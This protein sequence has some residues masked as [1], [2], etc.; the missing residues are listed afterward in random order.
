MGRYARWGGVLLGLWLT[1]AGAATE[2]PEPLRGWEAWV[3]HG[4]DFRQCPIQDLNTLDSADGYACSLPDTVRIEI[5]AGQAQVRYTQRVYAAGY[6]DLVYADKV[7]P[8][9]LS[10]DGK[11]AAVMPGYQGPRLWLEPGEHALSY[12]LDL[13][14]AP[15]AL[16]VPVAMRLLD[17]SV[18]GR[19]IFP[20]AREG[21][22][23]WLE[24]QVSTTEAD[25]LDTTV[26]RLWSDGIPQRLTTRIAL[27][28]AGKAREIRLGPAWPEGYELVSVSGS[29]PA[30]VEPGRMLRVQATAGSYQLELNARATALA[31]TLTASLP[32]DNWPAQE[33]WSFA[34]DHR[35]RVVDVSGNAPIDPAQGDVPSDWRS[36]PAYAMTEG[37][38][39]SLSERSR[40]LGD[41]A[42]RVQLQRQLWLDFDGGGYT[43]QDQLSGRMRQGF[44][45]DLAAPYELLAASERGES[46]LVTEGAGAGLRGVE[47][48]YPNLNLETTA[49]LPALLQLPAHGWNERLDGVSVSLHLPPGYR[50]LQASGVDRA[51]EAWIERWD[52]YEVFIAAFT[53]VLAWRFGGLRLAG[54]VAVLVVL[55][56]HEP[57]VP[58]YSLIALLLLAIAW[59]MLPVGR[60]R[61]FVAVATLLCAGAFALAALPFA[62]DQARWALHPQLAGGYSVS[63]GL[64]F[65][66]AARSEAV[67][68][69]EAEG[70]V[71]AE[72]APPPP[73]APPAP[74]APMAQEQ[75]QQNYLSNVQNSASNLRAKRAGNLERYAKDAVVQAG[76]GRPTWSWEQVSLGFDGPVD[77]AQM[78]SLWLLPPWLT[79]LW[80]LLLVAALA[81]IAL[82]LTFSVRRVRP[83]P[84]AAA[85][86]LLLGG[87]A[88][89]AELP[90]ASWLEA[91][92]QR[93]TEAPACAPQCVRLAET[94]VRLDGNRLQL[95]AEVHAEASLLVPVPIDDA[96]LLDVAVR[97]DGQPAAVLG[98]AEGSTAGWVAVTRG[99]HRIDLVAEVRGDRV[100]LDFSLTPA[101][102]QA[103]VPGW[104]VTGLRDGHLLS[105]RL[106]LVREAASEAAAGSPTARVPIK[107][108]VRIER[109]ISLDLD[110]TVSTR[111]IRL[112]P[113]D[114]GFSVRVP[115]L[116]GEQPGDAGLKVEDGR[117]EVT[118]QPGVWETTISSRLPR[119]ETLTL[120]AP[121]I[122]ERAEVWRVLVGPSLSMQA[123]GVPVSEPQDGIGDELW[124][125]EFNPLPGE[126][127]TL[128]I[129]RPAAVPGATLVAD[130]VTL[131]SDIG[132][133]SSTHTLSLQLRATQGGSHAL[134][135][136]EGAELLSVAINGSAL[137]LKLEAGKL[138]LPVRPGAQTLELSWRESAGVGLINRTPLVDLGLD[139]ANIRL[140]L[141]LP[142]DRWL[143]RLSGPA[144]GP[145]VLYW[146]GLIVL[147][148]IGYGLGRSGRALLPAG[149]W[150][151]LVLGFSTFSYIPLFV[152]AIGFLALDARQRYLPGALGKW[153]FDLIQLLVAG[154]TVAAFLALVA[155]IPAGLL[156]SPDMHIAGGTGAYSSP[157]WLADRAS[158]MLP[159]AQ[160]ISLPMWAYKAA[161]L[162]FALWL[163]YALL[164]WI[165]LAWQA[166]T[167]GGGWKPLRRAAQTAPAAPAATPAPGNE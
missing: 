97:L 25:A 49:R 81:G 116:A 147:L 69:D 99:V 156:G 51:P 131:S 149:H 61:M 15:D 94:T 77:S 166:L 31:D 164:R 28:V 78:V 93:L 8:R 167:H 122:G 134:T 133:R 80:R 126:Q 2:V 121:E 154:L 110:W 68:T 13:R 157:G 161:M 48:R 43:V 53:V 58:R 100:A 146:S 132:T 63:G 90:D 39:L 111:V 117:A 38:A 7:W 32:G 85:L 155:A 150:M 139:A 159:Q 14:S 71:V 9:D 73:P 45:L 127:L 148:A 88:S 129:T 18:D 163:A 3:L 119:S 96:A 123:S 35:L 21:T 23:L 138:T 87:G 60:L 103:D 130:S 107:P 106:E 98:R 44:R 145:A 102:V 158:G 162:L 136:P 36:Y 141:S 113:Q 153:S 104:T 67:I 135:L 115:L 52:I 54:V 62:I 114:G 112:A 37:D 95:S 92:K 20:L 118:L 17:L 89:A 64:D 57:E 74:A 33:V 41:D 30:V 142:S 66:Y 56:V 160:A 12:Q 1:A 86:L 137:N 65:G 152:V 40:G 143:L 108:Y 91:L 101:A 50:L 128:T 10:V 22:Q 19:R 46:L 47:L 55:G 151:L 59:R 11:T 105:E 4:E 84:L 124:V 75:I 27:H 70:I 24:R 109:E 76:I 140:N 26:H 125:H 144:I 42:N 72:P 120:T 82:L 165:K 29:L 5:A 83:A 79:A 16:Q 34:A 6:T